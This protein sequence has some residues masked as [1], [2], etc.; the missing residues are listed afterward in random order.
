MRVTMAITIDLDVNVPSHPDVT[1]T[2]VAEMGQVDDLAALTADI[3]Q[4]IQD[5]GDAMAFVSA[6][7]E[8]V[9]H[10]QKHRD[11]TRIDVW[12]VAIRGKL[13]LG[14]SDYLLDVRSIDENARL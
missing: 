11:T 2:T 9:A 8:L 1:Q 14:N 7:A 13:G 10:S 4:A 6:A 3:L 12:P 5:D